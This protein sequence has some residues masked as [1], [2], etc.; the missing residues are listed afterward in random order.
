MSPAAGCHPME[1]SWWAL[2]GLVAFVLA[3]LVAAFIYFSRPGRP[4]NRWLGLFIFL[5]AVFLDSW[6][7]AVLLE[8]GDAVRGVFVDGFIL[9]SA[10]IAP[11][12]LFLG[13]LDSPLAL[14]LR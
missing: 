3:T 11:Y 5:E 9:G 7:I 6:G 4:Q 14:P 1:W 13:T 2:P 12:L 10:S 8:D